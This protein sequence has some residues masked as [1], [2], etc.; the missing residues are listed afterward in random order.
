MRK[1]PIP[2]A[3]FM[4]YVAFGI[5]MMSIWVDNAKSKSTIMTAN[6]PETR[7]NCVTTCEQECVNKYK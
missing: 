2:L 6:V 7:E 1:F 4:L 5:L 3:W